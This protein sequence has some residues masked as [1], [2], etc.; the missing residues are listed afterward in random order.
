MSKIVVRLGEEVYRLR[1]SVSGQISEHGKRLMDWQEKVA[2][3][4]IAR[5]PW[6]TKKKPQTIQLVLP[7]LNIM[8][9]KCT[10]VCGSVPTP[11]VGS[12]RAGQK[13]TF[14]SSFMQ[15]VIVRS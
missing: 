6:K 14:F 9:Q 10:R 5:I 4:R 13:R 3:N 8:I 11:H 1:T 12:R 15:S 2:Y 7:R